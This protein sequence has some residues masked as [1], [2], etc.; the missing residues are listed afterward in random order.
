[1]CGLAPAQAR[2]PGKSVGKKPRKKAV[3][4]DTGKNRRRALFY[5]FLAAKNV[6]L[7]NYTCCAWSNFT[8]KLLRRRKRGAPPPAHEA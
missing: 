8:L 5:A 2:L 3:P 4:A 1:M 7:L 6:I